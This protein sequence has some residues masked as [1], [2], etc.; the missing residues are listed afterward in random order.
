MAVGHYRN[1]RRHI[2][3][4]AV[5]TTTTPPLVGRSGALCSE[6]AENVQKVALVGSSIFSSS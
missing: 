4:A 3:A 2:A 1:R 5:V 6:L